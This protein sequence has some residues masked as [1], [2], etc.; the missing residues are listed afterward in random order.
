[1]SIDAARDVVRWCREL[2]CCSEEEGATTRTFLSPPMR[3]VHARLSAWMQRL[4]MHVQVDAA[5]NLRGVYDAAPRSSAAKP[6]R[7]I[8]GSHLDSVPRAGAFDGVLGVILAIAFVEQLDGRRLP[9]AIEVVGFSD[10]E[11][12]RFGVPFIGSRALAG[13]LDRQ[14]LDR[15]DLNGRR[16]VEAIGDYGLDPGQLGAALASPD[17][18]AYLE[19]HIEQGPVLDGLDLP[20]GIV[21]AIAGQSRCDVTFVGH[22]NHAGTTPMDLRRDALACAAEWISAVETE[23]VGTPGFVATVGRITVEPGASNVIAG[24]VVATL[25]V[26]HA[27]DAVRRAAVTRLVERADTIA[28]RRNVAA[29]CEPRLDQA[30]VPMDAALVATL[31]R[32]VADAGYP[33]HHMP[34]G[35]GHDAMVVAQRIPAAMLLLR[36]PG[37]ISHH[38]DE[39]VRDEDVSAALEVGSRFLEG[40]AR[41]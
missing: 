28:R 18:A 23:A 9:C 14:L 19:C 39:A 6:R 38:P 20:V 30:A 21:D 32:A 8:I 13:T 12:T 1:M 31:E 29:A 41:G 10:E 26:R 16:L 25:D 24:R 3:E 27:H 7:I 37:G 36:S 40:F 15:A 33:V 22:A 5:G 2:A 17:V 35:A 11:G 34:C 4:G